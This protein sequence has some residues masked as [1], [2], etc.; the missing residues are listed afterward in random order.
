MDKSELCEEDD[1]ET[2]V[3]RI[4]NWL[5]KYAIFYEGLYEAIQDFTHSND[6]CDD[7]IPFSFK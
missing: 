3:K 5:D 4:E 7:P 2:R 1:L 6:E